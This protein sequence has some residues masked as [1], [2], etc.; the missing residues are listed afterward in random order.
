[1]KKDV[2]LV[3]L[4][5]NSDTSDATGR[6]LI[7]MLGSIGQFEIEISAERQK[8][9]F[10]RAKDRGV[11]FGK[12]P[13]FAADQVTELR[14]KQKQRRQPAFRGN[15]KRPGGNQ[16]TLRIPNNTSALVCPNRNQRGEALGRRSSGLDL[17]VPPELPNKTATL[18]RCPNNPHSRS[19]HVRE[20]LSFK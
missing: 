6:L 8:D 20:E 13:A 7:N 17:A 10:K 3:V 16:Q 15:T 14:Q 12:R 5:Q 19:I 18:L 1:M 11:H 4:D 9:G 2:D